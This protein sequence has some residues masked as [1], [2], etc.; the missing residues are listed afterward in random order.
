LRLEI[1]EDFDD[2]ALVSFTG[3]LNI[4]F[5]ADSKFAGEIIFLDGEVVNAKYKK[6]DGFKAL[7][8][9]CV[10]SNDTENFRKVLEPELIL[11]SQRKISIPLGALKR[12]ISEIFDRYIEAEKLRPPGNM[13]LL[14]RAEVIESNIEISPQEYS[15]LCT[16]SDYNMV[17]DVYNNNEM[18]DFEITQALVSLR[19]KEI[20]K[21]IKLI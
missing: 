17:D 9:L 6:V 4:L 3:R 19:K 13:K 16:L 15:L 12:K 20:I 10:L 1:F 5:K 8:K 2:Q 11:P 7:M 14:P 18:L 21:V